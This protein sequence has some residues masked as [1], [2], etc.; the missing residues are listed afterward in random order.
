MKQYPLQF[1]SPDDDTLRNTHLMLTDISL[2]D[3]ESINEYHRVLP[4]IRKMVEEHMHDHSGRIMPI[5]RK[6]R[7]THLTECSSIAII[8]IVCHDPA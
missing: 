2:S 1:E 4:E 8:L 5:A 7:P 6:P 3:T